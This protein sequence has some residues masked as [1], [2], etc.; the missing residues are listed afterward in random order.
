MCVSLRARSQSAGKCN[1]NCM[2]FFLQWSISDTQPCFQSVM[3]C[4]AS[5][6]QENLLVTTFVSPTFQPE[7]REINV[8]VEYTCPPSS[9]NT[10]FSLLIY[11]TSIADNTGAAEFSNYVEIESVVEN[12]TRTSR[13][14]SPGMGFYLAFQDTASCVEITRVQVL[15][16]VCAAAV[17]TL[18]QYVEVASSGASVN[19]MCVDGAS[20]VP[21][22]GDL[23]ATCRFEESYDFT[24]SGSCQCMAGR[25]RRGN[26]CVGKLF[27]DDVTL[28]YW[29]CQCLLGNHTNM[30]CVFPCGG[31][32]NVGYLCSHMH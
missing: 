24:S 7:S 3:I 26:E 22:S 9:C 12:A 25:Q 20:A 6:S 31:E 2:S 17:N 19:G 14:L 8:F 21:E 13:S 1:F 11:E 23:S 18:V 30:A 10:N 16:T 15:D 5:T 4:N 29:V 27:V 32:R 28:V